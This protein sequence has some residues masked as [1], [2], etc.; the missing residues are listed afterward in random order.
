MVKNI[1]PYLEHVKGRTYCIVTGYARL[2]LYKL[3]DTNV[4]LIDSGLH[5]DGEGILAC[6]KKEGL[7][8][9]AVLTSH[10]H[11]DHVGN[12]LALRQ[13]FG[14]QIYM[15]LFAA[16]ANAGPVNLASCLP[17]FVSYRQL[18]PMM[19]EPFQPDEI[20]D[21]NSNRITIEGV[22][23]QILHLP[24]HDAEHMGFITP[25]NV[26]YLGDVILSEPILRALRTSYTTCVEPDLASKELTATL[27]C[28]RYIVA[29]NGVYDEIHSLALLNR[30]A[31]LEK[32][33][34]IEQLADE[35]TTLEG[36][37]AKTLRAT[38]NRLDSV[39]KISGTH[40]NV[41][42]LVSYLVDVGRLK[43]RGRDGYLEYIRAD[44]A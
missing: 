17:D 32:A 33:A 36:L 44:L 40:H 28:D 19:K 35:Y 34:M 12:H 15:S 4:I 42:V 6:L 29:H 13:T 8:V 22:T 5:E 21:W 39:R 18:L 14:A 1:E 31:Q 26:A 16:A 24:G 7:T 25:D 30:D 37:V 11:I 23:F 38:G 43:T 2:P 41:S 20:I 9:K 3:D 27:N 10:S